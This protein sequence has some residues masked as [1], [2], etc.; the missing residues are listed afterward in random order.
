MANFVKSVEYLE[1]A[2]PNDLAVSV[3]LTKSQNFANCVP[4][5]TVNLTGA[6]DDIIERRYTEVILESGPKVTARRDGGSGDALVGVFVVEF[7]TTGNISVQ[8]G[9]FTMT[10]TLTTAAITDVVDITKAFVVISYRQSSTV[11]DFD[12]GCVKV[13]FNS[14]T[15]LG[16]SRIASDGTTEGRYF[17]VATSG[18]D[19]SVQHDT[20]SM[21]AT[22]ELTTETISVVTLASSFLI[23]TYDNSETADD[24]D[25]GGVV[26]DISSTTTVRA[27]RAFNDFG[28]DTA[29]GIASSAAVVKTQVVSAGGSE[30][31]VERNECN[32]GN[33]L[34]Q[35]V[36]ITG[37][38]QAKAIVIGGGYQGVMS[39]SETNGADVDGNYAILD[40]TSDTEVTGTRASNTS[41]DG[42]TMFEV[43]EFGLAAAAEINLVMAPYIP[44]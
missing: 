14:T 41:P 23:N 15:E 28:D 43:V 20:I 30:F 16:F 24:H 6:V 1:I 35:A 27:R 5:F 17:I 18:T 4:F 21:G 29:D 13:E 2:L 11:D 9:T 10:G 40:F 22:D 3:N 8:Q 32:W 37:I 34:T 39:S 36:A 33:S 38:D 7:D 19:F 42:T 12:A 31:S 44:A 26:V 25:Q